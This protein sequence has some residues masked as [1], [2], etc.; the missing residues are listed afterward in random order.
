MALGEIV[1]SWVVGMQQFTLFC[2][3]CSVGFGVKGEEIAYLKVQLN[4]TKVIKAPSDPD[5]IVSS[6]GR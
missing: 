6:R 1:L 2:F 4:D 5:R 3:S